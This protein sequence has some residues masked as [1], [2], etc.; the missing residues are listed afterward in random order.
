[1]NEIIN[2]KNVSLI[3]EKKQIYNL[4]LK[5]TNGD[6][7]VINGNNATGKS[8]LLKLFCLKI[9]PS[10]GSFYL[11]GK[12]IDSTDKKFILDY[13]KKIGVILQNDYLIPFFS[14]Y[15]NIELASEIQNYKSNF[16]SRI[17]Q[18][19][20]WLGLKEIENTKVDKLSKGEKQKVV[21]ARALI[22]KPEIIIAD[23]PEN[24][25]DKSTLKKVFFLFESLNKQGTTII[26]TSNL[27]KIISVNYKTINLD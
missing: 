19:L 22:N 24:F 6:F 5:V 14:V 16:K 1:M 3:L 17:N 7:F 9:L 20:D 25:L 18:I 27:E 8:T 12:R 23:Q 26:I 13:R 11:K 10:K 21:I 4:N 2:L 15:E